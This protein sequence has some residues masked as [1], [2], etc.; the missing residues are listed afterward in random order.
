MQQDI[1]IQYMENVSTAEE[2]KTSQ[3]EIVV[4]ITG[5]VE[6]EGIVKLEEG[7]R[8]ADAIEKAGGATLDAALG[9]V[10]L[11]YKLKDGQ[12]IH[13]PSNIEENKETIVTSKGDG[14][15]EDESRTD[16]KININ[17]ATQTELETLTG[18]GPSMALTIIEYREKHG[19]FSKIED[20][21]NISRNRRC[22]I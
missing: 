22:K 6:N 4:H 3:K 7:A 8:I 1:E 15:L 18:I 16:G 12:K 13:I 5:C 2:E 9:N 17:T 10:N 11:A 14:I 21:K 20:I 19:D